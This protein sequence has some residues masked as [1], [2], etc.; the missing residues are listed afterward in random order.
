M[1]Y[2]GVCMNIEKEYVLTLDDHINYHNFYLQKQYKRS[3][4]MRWIIPYLPLFYILFSIDYIEDVSVK[5]I[6]TIISLSIFLY[7][8]IWNLFSKKINDKFIRKDFYKHFVSENVKLIITEQSIIEYNNNSEQKYYPEWV[9]KCES[10]KDYIFL[11]S[12]KSTVLI[13]PKKYF[14]NEEQENIIKYYGGKKP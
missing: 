10:E 1:V 5:W 9:T 12:E 7:Y 8:L 11:T 13:F 2:K 4:S 3:S 14:S 6:G